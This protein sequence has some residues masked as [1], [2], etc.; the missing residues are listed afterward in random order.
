M[1]T[2]TTALRIVTVLTIA[3]ATC[4]LTVPAESGSKIQ[5]SMS[6]AVTPA[7]C[8]G[9]IN[10]PF[11]LRA[12]PTE[13]GI[14]LSWD[15][16]PRETRGFRMLRGTCP[17]QVKSIRSS[18]WDP[19]YTGPIPT[20]KTDLNPAP[21]KKYCY[22]IWLLDGEERTI[23]TSAIVPSAPWT[24]PAK[25]TPIPKPSPTPIPTPT[26]TPTPTST[27]VPTPTPTPVPTL[28]P[29]PSVDSG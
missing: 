10:S 16:N 6:P 25:A 13:E 4:I 11:A 14:R 3:L 29:T 8:E 20:E 19:D 22:Q 18:H 5:R 24:P 23:A 7:V 28:T 27:P 21:G 1:L 15:C 2:K 26:P 12:S 9:P 17:D